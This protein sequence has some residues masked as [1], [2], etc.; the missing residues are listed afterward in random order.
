[1]RTSRAARSSRLWRYPSL[2]GVH[3]LQ[4]P[5][6][7]PCVRVRELGAPP[8]H[9]PLRAIR[10]AANAQRHG[11]LRVVFEVGSLALRQQHLVAVDDELRKRRQKRVEARFPGR[12]RG[13]D[14]RREQ[15]HRRD[16]GVQGLDEDVVLVREVAIQPGARDAHG[17]RNVVHADVV[18]PPL[19]KQPGGSD[20]ELRLPPGSACGGPRPARRPPGP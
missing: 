5:A 15:F 19:L 6:E 11:L 9:E 4:N 14:P 10:H 13:Q 20:Q 16:L 17:R 7:Q 2:V 3:R 1:M 12:V 8:L 18:V